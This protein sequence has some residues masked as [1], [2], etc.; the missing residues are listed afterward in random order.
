MSRHVGA[1]S[2]SFVQNITHEALFRF[3]TLRRLRFRRKY[4]IGKS[5]D[6]PQSL[7]EKALI[8]G[9]ENRIRC[10]S[11]G[12]IP[13]RVWLSRN[14]SEGIKAYSSFS[15]PGAQ[16]ILAGDRPR[17]RLKTTCMYCCVRK[18]QRRATSAVLRVRDSQHFLG[19][20]HAR[21]QDFLVRRVTQMFEKQA[22]HR[23]PGDAQMIRDL[24]GLDPGGRATGNE[25]ERVAQH[26]TG[27]RAGC[28]R[29]DS[30]G[31]D[32]QADRRII[33]VTHAPVQQF[34]GLAADLM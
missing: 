29:M 2:G 5:F 8:H 14:S 16:G 1:G 4:A 26:R 13:G 3:P 22:L 6:R 27:L 31:R 24:L 17:M 33:P 28:R 25:F 21:A 23:R 9:S 11:G 7:A 34:G 15:R 20:A 12:H 19:Q 18:P 32:R 30:S 10:M